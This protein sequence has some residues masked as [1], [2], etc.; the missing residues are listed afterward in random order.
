[1]KKLRKKKIYHQSFC[2]VWL[3]VG[4]VVGTILVVVL[5][6]PTL[7][8]LVW[9]L[10][11]LIL[12]IYA[13]AHPTKT[14]LAL[15]FVAGIILAMVRISHFGGDNLIESW[16]IV[17]QARDWFAENVAKVINE[18]AVNLGLSYLMGMKNN[19]PANLDAAL[20]TVGLAHIVVASGTHLSI[21]VEVAQKIFG[22]ISR[23]AGAMFALLLIGFFMMIVGFT[24]SIWRAGIMAILTILARYV[25]RRFEPWRIIL[26]VMAITLMVN[27]NFIT[28][29]GW[30]LSFASYAGIMILAP[31]IQRYFYGE[32]KPN[33]LATTII[34]TVAATIMTLPITLY[35]F[36]SISLVAVV[37]N[38]IILPTLP[39]AMGLVF[40]AGITARM[41]GVG[42]I[43][44]FLATKLLD[45][46][47][48]IVEFLSEQK[49]M[50]IEIGKNETWVFL[51]Y[52][53]IVAGFLI[54]HLR[55]KMLK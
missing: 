39:Y 12:L 7:S 15:M 32:Q 28:N 47:I 19:L 21:L 27:P 41:P 52:A 34:T 29:L 17:I 43:M 2:V 37:A 40:L 55:E 49:Y 35:Y 26:I 5:K 36:G 31:K 22:K 38:L 44:G 46:H 10:G 48:L 4:I 13:C 23:F 45:L 6:I 1:M 20:K 33:F 8:S 25:G 53:P 54:G 3:C 24:P 11:V 51:M 16:S 18:P 30:I 9:L 14:F 42:E 50:M